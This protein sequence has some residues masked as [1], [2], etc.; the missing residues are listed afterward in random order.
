[1]TISMMLELEAGTT[2]EGV[3]RVLSAM[4][5][6]YGLV[7]G[8]L[9]GS[10]QRSNCFFSFISMEP[11]RPIVAEQFEGDWL[12]SVGGLF[13]VRA[14]VMECGEDDIQDFLRIFCRIFS[15][16]FVLSFQYEKI[17]SVRGKAGVE[18]RK[19]MVRR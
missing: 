17:Y 4:N 13:E 5:A 1:M 11:P 16:R 6:S 14:N 9:E 18:V 15:F 19:N 2:L 3:S 12:A 7:E 10:F 8:R